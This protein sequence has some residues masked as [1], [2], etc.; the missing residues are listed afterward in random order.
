MAGAIFLYSTSPSPHESTILRAVR[1][2]GG[3][4]RAVALRAAEEQ[5]SE[6][7]LARLAEHFRGDPDRPVELIDSGLDQRPTPSIRR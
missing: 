3:P 4:I 5:P 7:G 2:S 6:E 1:G